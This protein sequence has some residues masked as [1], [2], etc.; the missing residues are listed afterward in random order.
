MRSG[1]LRSGLFLLGLLS[2]LGTVAPSYAAEEREPIEDSDRSEDSEATLHSS[3]IVAAARGARYVRHAYDERALRAAP[4]RL[5][6]PM[7]EPTHRA[8][9]PRRVIPDEPD[10]PADA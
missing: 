2:A 6:P 4:R 5:A 1:W 9:L 8:E 3:T 10:E 7:P